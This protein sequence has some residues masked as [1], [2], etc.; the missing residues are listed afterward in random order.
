MISSG[1]PQGSLLAS[2]LFLIYI[3][4]INQ[5][6]SFH[7]T[8]F[9]GDIILHMST[10]CSDVLQT[11]VNLELCKIYHWL[12]VNKF[13]LNYYKKTNFMLLNYLK[14]NPTSLKV[15]INNHSIAPKDNLKYLGV[16]LDNK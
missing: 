15:I 13:S 2:L 10:S 11:A 9:A 5:A 12:R 14:Q 1:A 16:L 4:D 6:S 7:T 8:L 3:N